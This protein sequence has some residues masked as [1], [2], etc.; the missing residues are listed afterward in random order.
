MEGK[1]GTKLAFALPFPF[2]SPRRD[3]TASQGPF[4]DLCCNI[5]DE[6]SVKGTLLNLVD[7]NRQTQNPGAE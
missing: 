7:R 6:K 3:G 2:L 1:V 5:S 4:R